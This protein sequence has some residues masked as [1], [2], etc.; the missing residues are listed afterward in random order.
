MRNYYIWDLYPEY[1]RQARIE[2]ERLALGDP[3]VPPELRSRHGA[4]EELRGRAAVVQHLPREFRRPPL[5]RERTHDGHR[6]LTILARDFAD[7]VHNQSDRTVG[8]RE[9][10]PKVEET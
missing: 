10:S 9:R 8:R 1:F 2:L 5:D 6:I 7:R 4:R 3:R